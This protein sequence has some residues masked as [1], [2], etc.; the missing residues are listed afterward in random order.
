MRCRLTCIAAG[1]ADRQAYSNPK[2][3]GHGIGRFLTC[4]FVYQRLMDA[5]GFAQ[6]ESSFHEDECAE[7]RGRYTLVIINHPSI[8]GVLA[9]GMLTKRAS[10]RSASCVQKLISL[11]AWPRRR[12]TGATAIV[13]RRIL[14]AR[15][16]IPRYQPPVSDGCNGSYRY[17]GGP[18]ADRYIFVASAH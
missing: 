18:M 5:H 2:F 12:Y 3:D 1:R 14:P 8:T 15:C 11:V 13:L 7:R 17:L 4:S 6:F 9:S 16:L 10:S